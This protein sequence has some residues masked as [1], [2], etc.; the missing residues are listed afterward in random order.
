MKD[1]TSPLLL[2]KRHIFVC[3]NRREADSPL[4][5]GCAERGDV[6][7]DEF[8]NEVLAHGLHRDVWI[9]KTHCLGI[10]PKK[11]ATVAIYGFSCPVS[12]PGGRI[13]QEVEPCDVAGLL[14]SS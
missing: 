6:L 2:P 13:V 10:C 8:K 11:G 3:A 1:V 7:F 5:S 9:T 12:S 14:M 4:G